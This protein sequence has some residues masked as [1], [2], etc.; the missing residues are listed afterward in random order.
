MAVTTQI[1]EDSERNFVLHVI[2]EADAA[3]ATIVDVSGLSANARLGVPT[4]VRL[5]RIQYDTDKTIKFDWDATADITFFVA[6][7]GQDT[8]CFK[9]V[10]GIN[11]NAGTGVTGD[12]KIPAPAAAADYSATLWFTKKFG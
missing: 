7:P 10:G 12:V 3:G 2:G 8:K 5:D 9:D 4:S 1:L 6:A 11:N